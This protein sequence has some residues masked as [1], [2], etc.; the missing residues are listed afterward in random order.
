MKVSNKVSVLKTQLEHNCAEFHGYQVVWNLYYFLLSSA[1]LPVLDVGCFFKLILSNIFLNSSKVSFPSPS[2]SS[3]NDILR[4]L[5]T[6]Q[7]SNLLH[8]RIQFRWR[9]FAAEV[10]HLFACD[11]AAVILVQGSEGQLGPGGHLG[12]EDR[13][14]EIVLILFLFTS[15]TI[16]SW[17]LSNVF[18]KKFE[19][20]KIRIKSSFFRSPSAPTTLWTLVILLLETFQ[21]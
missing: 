2:E 16:P 10:L 15:V 11:V 5:F 13:V 12:L 7:G 17:F 8:Q 1:L 21:L 9:E 14:K 19:L 4:H 6:Q 20:C 18:M 3:W